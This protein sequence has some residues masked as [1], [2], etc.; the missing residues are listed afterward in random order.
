[1]RKKT[2]GQ[3]DTRRKLLVIWLRKQL[4]VHRVFDVYANNYPILMGRRYVSFKEIYMS[5]IFNNFSLNSKG[6]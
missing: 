6:L 2:L 3:T 4:G 5:F 1:M